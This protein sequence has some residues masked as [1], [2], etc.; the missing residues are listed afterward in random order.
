MQSVNMLAST[1]NLS[2]TRI[3]FRQGYHEDAFILSQSLFFPYLDFTKLYHTQ[4]RFGGYAYVVCPSISQGT[5]ETIGLT[6]AAAESQQQSRGHGLSQSTATSLGRTWNA[7]LSDSNG[8]VSHW[9]QAQQASQTVGMGDVESHAVTDGSGDAISASTSLATG[10]N[11]TLTD[12]SGS[13]VQ[14]PVVS[15]QPPRLTN[16]ASA[17]TSEGASETAT[18]SNAASHSTSHAETRGRARANHL[19]NSQGTTAGQGGSTTSSHGTAIG[20]GESDTE[21]RGTSRSVSYAETLGSSL[22]LARSRTQSKNVTVTLACTPIALPPQVVQE[23]SGRLAMSTEDQFARWAALI[24]NLP[25][26]HC[27]V[28][29]RD[30]NAVFTMRV[31]DVTDPFARAGCPQ[32]VKAACIASFVE[33]MMGWH[34]CF[35]RP[36][37]IKADDQA[38]E[39]QAEACRGTDL[40]R[41]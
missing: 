35:Y 21:T 6:L 9:M 2:N 29:V 33:E 28:S 11:L 1:L 24:G 26:Q 10:A 8:A 14:M 16:N 25:K 32:P 22:S 20:Q 27:V 5:G 19:A 37:K 34:P 15:G 12:Q 18:K 31:S 39:S 41:N 13:G 7:Q 40:F 23:D 38:T 4:E 3:T 36:E 30:Y 17:S